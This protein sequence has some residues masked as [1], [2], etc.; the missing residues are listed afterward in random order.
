MNDANED[1][2]M[3]HSNGDQD[4]DLTSNNIPGGKQQE[5]LVEPEYTE[6]LFNNIYHCFG[7]SSYI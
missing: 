6:G 4:T 5:P 7:I 2:S 3:E 1:N